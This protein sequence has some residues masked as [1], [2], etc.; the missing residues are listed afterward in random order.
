M[1]FFSLRV[2]SRLH[3]RSWKSDLSPS[4]FYFITFEL[5]SFPYFIGL[6]SGQC[7]SIRVNWKREQLA[8]G[9]T[10]LHCFSYW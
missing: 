9:D 2:P 8:I 10:A 6:V 1:L 5:G 4:L 7:L 3:L